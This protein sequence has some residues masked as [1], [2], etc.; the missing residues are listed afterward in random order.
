MS[1]PPKLHSR[2]T[3]RQQ[4]LNSF[5]KQI[6]FLSM[7]ICGFSFTLLFCFY[8]L[9]I[10]MKKTGER[11]IFS[12]H[13]SQIRSVFPQNLLSKLNLAKTFAIYHCV[14]SLFLAIAA[15][16]VSVWF[17][18]F[19]YLSFCYTKVVSGVLLQFIQLD[20]VLINLR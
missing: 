17:P 16:V 1:L 7:V 8:S 3:C 10:A 15:L 18:Y 13:A 4:L 9:Q 2:L 11:K 12:Y 6:V 14:L 5:L 20:Y 19:C